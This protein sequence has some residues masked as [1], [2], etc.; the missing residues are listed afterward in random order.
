MKNIFKLMV[1]KRIIDLRTELKKQKKNNL[2][3]IKKYSELKIKYNKD[4]VIVQ[5]VTLKN[6]K[7]NFFEKM[8]LK[9]YPNLTYVVTM[10]FNNAT[11]RTMILKSK[12]KLTNFSFN[13]NHNYLIDTTKSLYDTSLNQYHLFY[14]EN[15]SSPIEPNIIHVNETEKEIYDIVKPSNVKQFVDQRFLKEL[16]SLLEDKPNFLKWIIIGGIALF[17]LYFILK[18]SGTA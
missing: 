6:L 5:D 13:R 8:N 15:H 2:E 7:L 17:I 10:R 1:D 4:V 18:G 14:D 9:R 16:V 11:C 12:E 3:H